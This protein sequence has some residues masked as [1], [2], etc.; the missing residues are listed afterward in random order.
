[1]IDLI[2]Q[3]RVWNKHKRVQVASKS[4]IIMD[5][6]DKMVG[7]VPS[8]LYSCNLANF[9][10]LMAWLQAETKFNMPSWM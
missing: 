6:I 3:E 9:L 10:E 4:F 8:D 1:M 7:I 5:D 2:R